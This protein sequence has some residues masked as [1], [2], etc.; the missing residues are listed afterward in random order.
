MFGRRDGHRILMGEG[1]IDDHT[2]GEKV[3][4][5]VGTATGMRARQ[6]TVRREMKTKNSG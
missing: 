3:E 1:L 4:I 5:P 6:T 2:V